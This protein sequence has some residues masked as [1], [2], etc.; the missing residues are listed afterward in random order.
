MSGCAHKSPWFLIT[1]QCPHFQS[2]TRRGFRR[3]LDV[4]FLWLESSCENHSHCRGN[5]PRCFIDRDC[6]PGNGGAGKWGLQGARKANPKPH[7]LKTRH[8]IHV[9]TTS[10]S[11]V[12]QRCYARYRAFREAGRE[13]TVTQRT[14]SKKLFS[15]YAQWDGR[16]KYKV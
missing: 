4:Y 10:L 1:H 6:V 14:E 16:K 13:L 7:A 15:Q 5:T 12:G 8:C 3:T 11:A 2:T 9:S